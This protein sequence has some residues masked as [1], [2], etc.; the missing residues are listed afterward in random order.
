MVSSK[1]IFL[2]HGRP[3]KAPSKRGDTQNIGA[4]PN[5]RRLHLEGGRPAGSVPRRQPVK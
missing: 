4:L 1:I 2:S 3:Q 5:A